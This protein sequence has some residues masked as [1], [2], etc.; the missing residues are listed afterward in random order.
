MSSDSLEFL[1]AHRV[2]FLM[3]QVEEVSCPGGWWGTPW[4]TEEGADALARPGAARSPLAAGRCRRGEKGLR[5]FPR[6][7]RDKALPDRG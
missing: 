3:W 1:A 2:Y 6:A 5:R 4:G 7:T